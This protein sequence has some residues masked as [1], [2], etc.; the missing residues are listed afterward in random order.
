[1]RN[2]GTLILLIITFL[3]LGL[4]SGLLYLKTQKAA[5]QLRQLAERTLTRQLDLPVQIGSASLSLLHSSVELHQITVGELP[6]AIPSH[7]GSRLDRPLLMVDRASAVFRLAALLRGAVQLR[8]LTLHAPSL[9]FTD[10]S[11]SLSSLSTLASGLGKTSDDRPTEEF[12][13]LLERGAVAYRSAASPLSVHIG[14]LGGRLFWT[15][16]DRPTVELAADDVAVRIGTCE[17]RNIRLHTRAHPFGNGVRVEQIAVA[18]AGSSLAITGALG[19]GADAAQTDLSITGEL[20]PEALP[21]PRGG[22]TASMGNLVVKGRIINEPVSRTVLASLLLEDGTGALVGQSNATI[23]HGLFTLTRLSLSRGN[24]RLAVTGTMDL[25]RKISNLHLDLRGRL[26][27]LAGWFRT[28][29]PIAGPLGL[30]LRII[31]TGSDLTGEGRLEIPQAKIGSE[32]IERLVAGLTV[33]ETGLAIPSLTGRYHGIP[34]TASASVEAGG[35]YR[36]ALLPTKIDVVSIRRL[37]EYGGRGTIVVSLAGSGQGLEPHIDGEL[38]LHD[39]ALREVR[40]GRGQ[41]RFTLEDGR[42][43]WTLAGSRTLQATGVAPLLLAGPL[44]IDASATDM[45][46]ALLFQA[47]RPRMRVP[48]TARV[49]GRLRVVG[50]LP[51]LS[52]LTGR[53]DLDDLRGTAGST[54]LGL[55]Q[56]T[57]I[58]LEPETLHIDSLGLI[59]PGLSL[60]LTGGIRPGG[61]LDLSLSGYAP[62][63]VIKPWVPAVRDL[64]GAPKLQLSLVGELKAVRVTGRAELT[65]IRVQPKIIPIWI[66]AEAGE[67]TF[68][69]DRVRYTVAEG[70]LAEGGLKGEGIAQRDGGSWHHTL[71]FNIDRAQ[72]DSINDQLLPERRWVTGELSTRVALAFDTTPHR[73]TVPSLQGQLITRLKGG[74][75]SHYPA[76]IRLFGLLGAPAQPYRLPDLTRERM[77]YRKITADITVKDGIMHTTNLLLD[78][79]VMRL[80]G[81][82]QLRVADQHVALDLAVRPLQVLEQGIRRI[83]LLGRILPKTQSLAVTRFDMEGPWDDP[84]ISVAPV[85]SLSHTLR[86]LLLLPLLAPWRLVAPD[87]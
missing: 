30:D 47:L 46:L 16:P 75:L 77:P 44:Q 42:W 23:Q 82:G 39:L 33:T 65:Q 41:I 53:I 14:G 58:M 40:L 86:D 76:L 9:Q 85:K 80:T 36:F 18:K 51:E 20:A 64:Q 50:T 19:I 45:D 21:F 54:P 57:R 31:G 67:V 3:V 28:E 48:V 6:P 74:S 7:G 37:A 79:Q 11:A 17:L 81:V 61:R 63:D 68:N 32:Q 62:F 38:T 84:T 43:R 4:G 78:S 1:M 25:E 12:P 72:L 69:N 2:R 70:S 10:T 49:D 13:I 59:G 87:R 29:I 5:E 55:R 66:F 71:E 26:E 35:A 8:S 27:D 15:A 24:S 22:Q 56:P 52:D 34:F 60:T 83:P 73:A